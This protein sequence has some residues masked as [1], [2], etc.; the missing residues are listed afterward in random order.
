MK[1]L[2]TAEFFE[3]ILEEFRKEGVPENIEYVLPVSGTDIVRIKDDEF[4]VG[5]SVEPGYSEGLYCRI[6]LGGNI[7][8]HDRAERYLI[9]TVKTLKADLDTWEVLSKFAAA[10]AFKAMDYVWN[11]RDEF[12]WTGYR[13]EAEIEDRY[14]PLFS[15][16]NLDSIKDQAQKWIAS[17]K[18]GAKR[19]RIISLEERKEVATY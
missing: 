10:F 18:A 7:G 14:V 17:S 8:Y 19:I 4:D 9:G 3:K 13:A 2:T 16:R 1:P 11:H 5:F 12:R 6:Y 15:S